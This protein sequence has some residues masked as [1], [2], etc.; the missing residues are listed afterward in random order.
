MGMHVHYAHA[1]LLRVLGE[2]WRSQS[3]HYRN[4]PA[5]TRS[6]YYAEQPV[7]TTA[8]VLQ[9][10]SDDLNARPNQRYEYP[11]DFGASN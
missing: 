9:N 5:R 1:P 7:C 8:A 3:L 10:T 11:R 2:R 4:V 6:T